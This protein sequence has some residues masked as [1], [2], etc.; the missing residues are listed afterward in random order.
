[1][2]AVL[3]LR[4]FF[5]LVACSPDSLDSGDTADSADTAATDTGDPPDDSG[6]NDSGDTAG[7]SGAPTGDGLLRFTGSATVLDSFAGTETVSF[8]AEDGA[9][10]TVCEVA[11]TLASTGPREDCLDCAWAYDVTIT[12]VE[13]VVD[14][15][16]AAIGFSNPEDY[17]GFSRGMGFDPLYMGHAPALLEDSGDG[18][19]LVFGYAEWDETTG[20]LTYN[21]DDGYYPY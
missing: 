5:A 10:A 11:L 1:M 19:W 18:K 17:V 7:D 16:C 15:E 8:I 20:A 14:T 9:G 2:P 6:S 4:S 12:E 21:R 3:L 13:T